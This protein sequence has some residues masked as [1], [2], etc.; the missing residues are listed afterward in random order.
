[1]LGSR[2]VLSRKEFEERWHDIDGTY[3][4]VRAGIVFGGKQPARAPA[5]VHM[6]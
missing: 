6:D 5:R 3:R 4:N 1:V 2:A